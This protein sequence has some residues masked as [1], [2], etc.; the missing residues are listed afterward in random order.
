M[1]ELGKPFQKNQIK[2][3]KK[4]KIKIKKP[5]VNKKPLARKGNL[6]QTKTLGLE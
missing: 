1:S 2:N 6:V 5:H 4:Q 3:K